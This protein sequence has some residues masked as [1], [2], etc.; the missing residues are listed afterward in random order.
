MKPSILC[1][2]AVMSL[3]LG[4][5]A[6]VTQV[7]LPGA[8]GDTAG[9]AGGGGETTTSTSAGGAGGGP[10]APCVVQPVDP[11]APFTTPTCADLSVMT[12]RDLS[13]T[14]DSGDGK[15]SPGEGATVHVKLAE[16]AG[17]G[18]SYYPG[19]IFSSDLAV[20]P[21]Q[22]NAELYAILACQVDDMTA[23]IVIPANVAKGTVVH[24]KAQVSM[25]SN[26]C[27]NGDS[28]TI[29]ITVQ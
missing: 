10:A 23:H 9:G 18:F 21:D 5:A 4:A 20:V 11:N 22:G 14:D 29:P 1:A 3:S 2:V 15:V 24:V 7:D 28:V 16:I 8:T 26:A 17:K 25:L 13:V 6:C 19:V 27:T 12:V